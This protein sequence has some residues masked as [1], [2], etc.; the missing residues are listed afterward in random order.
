M[1]KLSNDEILRL[2]HAKTYEEF[3]VNKDLMGYRGKKFCQKHA[4]DILA[5]MAAQQHDSKLACKIVEEGKHIKIG[6]TLWYNFFDWMY[7]FSGQTYI[8]DNLKD[9]YKSI[10]MWFAPH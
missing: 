2:A 8:K 5:A 1:R 6:E 4:V 7:Q 9:I 10:S 3:L